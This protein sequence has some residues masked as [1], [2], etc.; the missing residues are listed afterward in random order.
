MATLT[1]E[2]AESIVFDAANMEGIYILAGMP[3]ADD[4][5]AAAGAAAVGAQ[6]PTG[7]FYGKSAGAAAANAWTGGRRSSRRLR[8][9]RRNRRTRRRRTVRNK[10][11]SV[12]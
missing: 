5:T 10:S 11:L 4:T 2:E 1:N 8:R 9:V 6:A 3:H 12:Y 7:A